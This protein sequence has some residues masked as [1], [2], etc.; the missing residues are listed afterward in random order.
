MAGRCAFGA[1]LTLIGLGLVWRL[2]RL[3]SAHPVTMP[4]AG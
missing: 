4:A 3:R 1:M 2:A